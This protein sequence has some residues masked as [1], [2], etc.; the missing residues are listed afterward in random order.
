M[1]T[2]V[3]LRHWD[4]CACQKRWNLL[5]EDFE[6]GLQRRAKDEYGRDYIKNSGY[7]DLGIYL[8]DMSSRK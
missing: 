5:L 4:A 1:R 6:N 2:A 3:Q 8:V 7:R